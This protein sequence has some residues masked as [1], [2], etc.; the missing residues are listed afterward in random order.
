MMSAHVRGDAQ[1]MIRTDVGVCA[2]THRSGTRRVSRSCS[3][4]RRFCTQNSSSMPHMPYHASCL[5]VAMG[6]GWARLRQLVP[7]TQMSDI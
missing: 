5:S 2:R 3:I 6:D 7:W 1:R 4:T